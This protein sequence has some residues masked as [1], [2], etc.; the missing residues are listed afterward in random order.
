MMLP[1][2]TGRFSKSVFQNVL[3]F[4]Q[5]GRRKAIFNT[6]PSFRRVVSNIVR[7]SVLQF[8]QNQRRKI[9][10]DT[11]PSGREGGIK[12]CFSIRSRQGELAWLADSKRVFFCKHCVVP[13]QAIRTPYKQRLVFPTECRCRKTTFD[14]PLG[15]GGYQFCSFKT[16]WRSHRT[17]FAKQFLISPR[18]SGGV[19]NIVFHSFLQFPQNQCRKTIFDTTWAGGNVSKIVFGLQDA[20]EACVACRQQARDLL[21]VVRCSHAMLASKI[22]V[23]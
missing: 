20:K 2:W 14:T 19:S 11:T 23:F 21:R 15:L 18:A 1:P 8:P 17:G 12:N 7:H 10:F 13:T 6:S 3:Q 22:I 16:L 9:I 5:N 4:P